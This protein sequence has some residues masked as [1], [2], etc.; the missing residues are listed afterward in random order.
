MRIVRLMR[1][2]PPR[3]AGGGRSPAYPK[4]EF[5]RTLLNRKPSASAENSTRSRSKFA[6]GFAQQVGAHP[7]VVRV[8]A[9]LDRSCI[10]PHGAESP[11]CRRA[12]R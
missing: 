4:A 12:V 1:S 11:S 8:D 9:E 5:F 7:L 3:A 10:A 6:V 2:L